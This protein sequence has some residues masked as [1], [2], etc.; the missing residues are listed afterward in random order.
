MPEALTP[1][2]LTP[3]MSSRRLQAL[4]FIELYFV[5]H[6]ESPTYSEIAAALGVSSER[7]K[8]LVRQLEAR[9]MLRRTGAR[10]GLVLTEP[11]AMVSRNQALLLLRREGWR[12]D[13]ATRTATLPNL[14]LPLAPELE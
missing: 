14:T 4:G 8:E 1:V 2:P 5:A 3:A 10:R 12:I 11:A 13:V 7:A 6:G 9:G